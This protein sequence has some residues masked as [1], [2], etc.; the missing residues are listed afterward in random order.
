MKGGL[1]VSS[2]L[3]E[4]TRFKDW[5]PP[6][7]RP[8]GPISE[9]LLPALTAKPGRIGEMPSFNGDP[10]TDDDLHLALYVCYEIHYRGFDG[11]DP[12]WEW[13]PFLLGFRRQLE[14]QFEAAA[15]LHF[16]DQSWDESSDVKDELNKIA[17]WPGPPLSR[18]MRDRASEAE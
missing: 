14:A 7:P 2:F 1:Q 12:R 16:R 5:E 13:E 11:V 3:A 15:V 8:R 9:I 6:L 4:S 18:Y 17:E 10:L